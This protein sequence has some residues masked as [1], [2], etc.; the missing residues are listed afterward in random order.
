YNPTRGAIADVLES[1]LGKM[2][3]G[4]LSSLGLS[5]GM[6]RGAAV[7]YASL[8]KRQ[9]YDFSFY[10]QGNIVG[11]GAFNILK[12]KGI[13]LGDVKVRMYG[14]PVVKIGFERFENGLGVNVI[15]AAINE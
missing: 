14:T 12:N 9:N 2:F 5:I 15:G 7:S 6:N 3:D 11:F 10:S 8:D 1:A 4:S 13:R